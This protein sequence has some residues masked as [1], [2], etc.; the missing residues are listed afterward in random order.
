MGEMDVSEQ[1][2]MVEGADE[3]TYEQKIAFCN[4][5]AKPMAPKKLAKKCYK[6]IKK[7]TLDEDKVTSSHK[8]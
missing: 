5:L 1:A 8:S 3:L 2:S 4:V 7:G 6:L